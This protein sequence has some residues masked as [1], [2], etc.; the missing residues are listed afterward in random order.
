MIGE[1]F[2][3]EAAAR[4]EPALPDSVLKRATEICRPI[5]EEDVSDRAYL[6]ALTISLQR[7]KTLSIAAREKADE[8]VRDMTACRAAMIQLA[9]Q[10]DRQMRYW[11][12]RVTNCFERL[13]AQDGDSFELMGTTL[14]ELRVTRKQIRSTVERLKEKGLRLVPS[15]Y[16]LTFGEYV[17]V[18][19]HAS[20]EGAEGSVV[21]I[22]DSEVVVSIAGMNTFQPNETLT[23]ARHQIAIWDYDSVF[24]DDS[25]WDMVGTS[26]QDSQQR[27][28]GLLSSLG[29]TSPS[30]FKARKINE[31]EDK[32]FKSSRERKAAKKT[33]K[34]VNAPTTNTKS[35]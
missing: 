8:Y 24:E 33:P 16:D 26:R 17:V 22:E 34:E 32:P 7:Q 14:D 23:L 31:K 1:S 4:S 3:L 29:N 35:K 10:Y 27:L 5:A 18:V 11:E 2:A 21:S 15:D 9:T 13:R 12:N 25:D 6:Q 28:S 20:W 19:D 30:S